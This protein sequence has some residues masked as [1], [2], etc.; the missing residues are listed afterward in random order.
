[1]E[2]IVRTRFAPSPTG[3]L[4]IGSI[5]TALFSWLWAKKNKG[6]FVLR[7]EDTDKKREVK[8]GVKMIVDTLKK[9]GLTMDEGPEAGEEH[10]PYK[11][12]ERL[13]IYKKY[14]RKLVEQKDAYHCFCTTER[15]EKMR[16]D[17]QKAGK[18]SRYDRKCLELSEEEVKERLSGGEKSVIRL[19]MPEDEIL[20]WTD[21]VMGEVKFNSKE[22]D[23]T[24][25]LKSDGYPTYHLAVVV[26]DHLMEISHVFRD[27]RWISS[28]PK[29]IVLYRALGWKMPFLVHLPLVLG[30]DK[31]P[32]SK[33]HGSVGAV[34]LLEEGYLPEALLNYLA[35]V[36]WNPKTD[37]ELFSI[38]GLIKKFDIKGIHKSGGVFDYKKLL[39]VNGWHISQKTDEE[40]ADIFEKWVPE[41]S[42]EIRLKLAPLLRTRVKK[43]SELPDLVEFLWKEKVSVGLLISKEMSEE[44]INKMKKMIEESRKIIEKIG[45]KRVEELKKKMMELIEKEGWKVGDFF[46]TFR[47][48]IAGSKVTPPIVECLSILGKEKVLVRLDRVMNKV[49]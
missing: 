9:F 17:Q 34:E 47:K 46:M 22:V 19:K 4:H 27:V 31:K 38:E 49:S 14:A 20:T 2:K 45:V 48:A 13:D 25:I 15:L 29:H 10:G 23:D 39:H 8:D 3:V 6:Q 44:D 16:K 21:L 35:L 41:L 5:R 12:S 26:D 42:K 28:T 11:Q 7:I 18:L 24:V 1:M 40:L 33:R 30:A 36:G 37:E 43:L 32:L